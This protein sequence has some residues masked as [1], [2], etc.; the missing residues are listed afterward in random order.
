MATAQCLLLGTSLFPSR[1]GRAS[2]Q[3]VAAVFMTGLIRPP[4]ASRLRWAM[5][6]AS[7]GSRSEDGWLSVMAL[8]RRIER[9]NRQCAGGRKV[10]LNYS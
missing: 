1:G 4:Q 8:S 3:A 6:R 9:G 5:A 10:S 2:S 7:R